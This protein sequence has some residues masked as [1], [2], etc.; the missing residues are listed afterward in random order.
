MRAKY[1][2]LTLR[3]MNLKKSFVFFLIFFILIFF[4]INIFIKNVEPTI[5]KICE[6][7]ARSIAIKCSNDAV[8]KNIENITYENLIKINKDDSGKVTSLTANSVEINKLNTS[9]INDIEENLQ[10]NSETVITIPI[11]MFF[12]ENII[13]GYGPRIKIKTYPLGDIKANLKSSFES[14]GINQT[15]HSLILE[16]T[17]EVRVLAPFV[18]EIEE[19]KSSIVIAETIIVSDTPSSYYNI[20]GVEGVEKKDTLDL[21]E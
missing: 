7:K 9:I 3:Q 12:D 20:T 10:N 11:G 16:V 19:Y 2:A 1:Y 4:F 6:N 18:S 5:T 8:Y 15:K 14:A 17:A 13:S 21:L